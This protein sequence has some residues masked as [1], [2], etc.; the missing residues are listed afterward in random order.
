MD[1]KLFGS[2]A[3]DFS[4]MGEVLRKFNIEVELSS[5]ASGPYR[6][7]EPSFTQHQS[8][9]VDH[10]QDTALNSNLKASNTLKTRAA[11]KLLDIDDLNDFDTA[12]SV[13]AK[14]K[15]CYSFNHSIFISF[16]FQFSYRCSK[17]CR[18]LY[19]YFC[20]RCQKYARLHNGHKVG[21]ETYLV[22]NKY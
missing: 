14:R 4:Q 12:C 13:S 3:T 15:F 19:H 10:Y 8:S 22:S 18:R 20:E 9:T 17:L 16:N 1:L 2:A 5:S 6:L 7:T 21:I 11:E